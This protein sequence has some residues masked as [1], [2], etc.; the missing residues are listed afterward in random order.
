MRGLLGF[1]PA[2]K[3]YS[4]ARVLSLIEEI[5]SN[6]DTTRFGR[7]SNQERN[8]LLEFRQTFGPARDGLDT[9]RG[10]YFLDHT[11]N[12]VYFS[13]ELGFGL[14]QVFGGGYYPDEEGFTWANESIITLYFKGDLGRRASYGLTITGG[15]F[16]VP[17]NELGLYNTFY[18]GFDNTGYDPWFYNRQITTF[19]EPRAFF[20]F[21]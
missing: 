13:G 6:N 12:D 20:P 3:P 4:Q 14:D 16:R 15:F 5:L 19:S 10:T 11:W 18:S 9:L 17:R 1:Q 2:A 21:T 7:L 8:I